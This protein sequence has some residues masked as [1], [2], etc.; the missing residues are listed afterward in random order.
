[1]RGQKEPGEVGERERRHGSRSGVK[2]YGKDGN[3]EKGEKIKGVG[4]LERGRSRVMD[5]E[6]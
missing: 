1:M 2:E 3:K 5:R 6:E 4:N